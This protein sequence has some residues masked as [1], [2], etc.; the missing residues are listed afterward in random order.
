MEWNSLKWSPAAARSGVVTHGF[1]VTRPTEA[2]IAVD[3]QIRTSLAKLRRRGN[4]DTGATY[5]SPVLGLGSRLA[6]LLLEA[7]R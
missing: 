6:G 4:W 2:S 7:Q 1:K 5:V 3:G